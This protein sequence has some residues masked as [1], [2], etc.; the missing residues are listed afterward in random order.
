MKG[1]GH[2]KARIHQVRGIRA[3]WSETPASNRRPSPWQGEQTGSPT[4]SALHQRSPTSGDHSEQPAAP[5]APVH[6]PSTAVHSGFVPQVF[7]DGARPL[8]VAQVA[9]LLGWTKDVVRASCE[10]GELAH[11]RDHLNAYRIPCVQRHYFLTR[12]VSPASWDTTASCWALGSTQGCPMRSP[13]WHALLVGREPARTRAMTAKVKR[14]REAIRLDLRGRHQVVR[15]LAPQCR[16]RRV[17]GPLRRASA[18]G[19]AETAQDWTS[20]PARP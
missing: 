8:D 20:A 4:E 5:D 1:D 10:R 16:S 14:R 12:L 3:I 7:Q 9:V 15:W 17:R 13:L 18:R 2:E 19:A 6:Q 11:T